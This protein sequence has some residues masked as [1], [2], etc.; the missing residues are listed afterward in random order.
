MPTLEEAL[1][2][3]L[4]GYSPVVAQPVINAPTP[5]VDLQPGRSATIRC[6]LPILGQATPD[7]LRSYFLNGQ[8][9]QTRL[10][11]PQTN[12]NNGSTGS[13]TGSTSV[14]SSSSTVVTTTLAVATATTTTPSIGPNVKFTGVLTL[15]KA[16]QLLS[17]TTS[18]PAR[19]QFY[20]TSVAR[21]NDLARALD[22]APG[23]GTAQ[24]II[25]DLVLDTAPYQWT[26]QDRIAAN[27]DNPQT[28]LIY[29]TVT[30]L[31]V[32]SDAITVTLNYVPLVN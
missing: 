9:P 28:T 16:F 4:E 11:S 18:S 1:G 30:N 13:S 2:A 3:N 25:C 8:V 15:A 6:P 7:S 20:G 23:A 26:F 29:V 14:S 10:L 27:G 32:T 19:I 22:A 12:S 24:N 17:V 31:D 21:A 5:S